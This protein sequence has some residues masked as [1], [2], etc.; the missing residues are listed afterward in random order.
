MFTAAMPEAQT[1]SQALAEFLLGR[2]LSEY[3]AE[4]RSARP[5]WSWQLIASQ[6][7]EDTAGRVNVTRET[8]RQWYGVELAEAAAS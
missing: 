5:Q 7:T 1:P 6:L 2:S 3:V 4:K 8:L